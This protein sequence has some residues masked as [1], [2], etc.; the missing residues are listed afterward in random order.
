MIRS[1]QGS[2][3]GKSTGWVVVETQ[4]GVGYRVFTTADVLEIAKGESIFLHCH[5]A[6]RENYMRL[7]GF[8]REDILD[9]FEHL[10]EVNG[11][12]PKGA[13]AI[14]NLGSLN[15]LIDAIGQG[16]AGYVSLA[17]GI[18][19]KTADK[20]IIELRDKMPVPSASGENGATASSELYDV[21]TSLG[22][23]QMQIR[24]VTAKIN[25]SMAI[26]E[27]IRE[28]LQIMGAKR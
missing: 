17:S 24:E 10:I 3:I 6:V 15:R 11:V 7:F 18:G 2:I 4:S 27:Q 12:G 9:L 19:K 20:V 28:A 16:D 5:L 21:L 22:Y 25:P 8:L 13:L 26:E 23:S 1:V 14:L